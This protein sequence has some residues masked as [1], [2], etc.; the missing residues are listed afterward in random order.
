MAEKFPN[1]I[2]D[3]NWSQLEQ[4][5]RSHT[6][7]Q[8]PHCSHILKAKY[9][10]HLEKQHITCKGTMTY[11]QLTSQ[12]LWRKEAVRL[13]NIFKG[14]PRKVHLVI[15][16]QQKLFLQTEADVEAYLV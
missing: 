8:G 2:K 15:N 3:R 13:N 9:K 14:F 7:L 11:Q 1:L 6:K 16:V 12:R 4:A 5:Y 10:N